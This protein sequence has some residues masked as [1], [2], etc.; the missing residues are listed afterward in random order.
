ADRIYR[1]GGIIT[2]DA[3]RPSA[4]AVAVGEGRILAVGDD[5]EVMGLAG[6]ST[7]VVDLDGATMLPGLV[8]GHG[9]V[10]NAGLYHGFANLQP[11]PAGPGDS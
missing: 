5:A 8:D 2:M 10:A 9:H 1:N 6:S 11:S 4:Q 7:D 3:A